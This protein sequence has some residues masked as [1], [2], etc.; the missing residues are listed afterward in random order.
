MSAKFDSP[1]VWHHV[2]YEFTLKLKLI[3]NVNVLHPY[4]ITCNCSKCHCHNYFMY[5]CVVPLRVHSGMKSDHILYRYHVC[6]SVCL[7][8]CRCL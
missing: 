6:L 7:S 5:E 8:V 2:E 3:G 1:E 4:Q